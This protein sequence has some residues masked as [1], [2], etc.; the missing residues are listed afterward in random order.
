MISYREY[1]IKLI[2]YFEKITFHY[3]LREEK[4]LVDALATLSSMFEV[5]WRNEAPF[6]RIDHLDEPTHFLAMET[7]CE[8]K[9]WFYEIK[10]YP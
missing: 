8:D 7:K 6:I 10:R 2:P 4:Q 3:I 9:P 5:E 1:I